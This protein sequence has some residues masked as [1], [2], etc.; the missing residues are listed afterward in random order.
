MVKSQTAFAQWVETASE[1]FGTLDSLRPGMGYK[2]YLETAPISG[3]FSYSGYSPAPP[4]PDTPEQDVDQ[5]AEIAEAEPGWSIDHRAYQYNMT[6]AA[7]LNIEGDE[8][9]S[10]NDLIAAFVDGECRGMAQPIYLAAMD[11]YVA[12][13]MIH[14]NSVSGETVEFQAFVPGARTVYNVAEAITYEADGSVGSIGKPLILSTEGIAFEITDNIP[15]RYSLSQNYP[16]PFNPLTRI[17]YG[18]PEQSH[19]TIEVFN[20][21]GQRVRTLVS[22]IQPA[23]R[24]RVVWDGKDDQGRDVGS[25]IYFYRL[26]AGEFSESKKM[27]ILK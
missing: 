3:E 10:D 1:W 4:W 2:L 20:V 7:V 18:L 21:L 24:H 23:G 22:A 15:T 12:F 19:A 11:R 8:C 27:V 6:V 17:E 26:Q 5:S 9:R 16:N 13:L 25:G 14:S